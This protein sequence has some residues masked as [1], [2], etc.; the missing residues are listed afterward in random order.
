ML[1]TSKLEAILKIYRC[2]YKTV[3]WGRGVRGGG[4]V[5]GGREW[6]RRPDDASYQVMKR[7]G[8]GKHLNNILFPTAFL[9]YCNKT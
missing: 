3:L 9:R 4:K 5:K 1:T 6:G 2:S 7:V 8:R